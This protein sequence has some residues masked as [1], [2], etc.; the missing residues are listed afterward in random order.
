MVADT[1]TGVVVSTEMVTVG[2][3]EIA[4]AVG[5][6]V[7]PEM[8]ATT[9]PVVCV[10]MSVSATA[11]EVTVC[12]EPA[13]WATPAPGDGATTQVVQLTAPVEATPM[14]EV[15][16]SPALPTLPMGSWPVT[17]AARF[18]AEEVSADSFTPSPVA[19]A[20][21]CRMPAVI[22]AG[23][24]IRYA[25]PPVAG[26]AKPAELAASVGMLPVPATKEWMPGVVPVLVKDGDLNPPVPEYVPVVPSS[27]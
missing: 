8:F 15:P 7:E 6:A 24:F 18:T 4:T 5:A 26:A 21:A 27:V 25:V 19:G 1:V 22:V 2:K 3:L 10:A 11:E 9:V 13:K 23:I 20:A 17:S 14:G 12:V 16:L